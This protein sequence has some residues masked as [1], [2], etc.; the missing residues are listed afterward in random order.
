MFLMD[1]A[2]KKQRMFVTLAALIVYK[3]ALLSHFID[4]ASSASLLVQMCR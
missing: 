1:F 3:K 2:S 4:I